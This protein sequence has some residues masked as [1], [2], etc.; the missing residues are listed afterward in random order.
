V[1]LVGLKK[2]GNDWQKQ[3]LRI[4]FITMPMMNNKVTNFLPHIFCIVVLGFAKNS[5]FDSCFLEKENSYLK[6]KIY[7][8]IESFYRVFYC[9]S[10]Q[11]LFLS[12]RS[13]WTRS[14]AS[15]SSTVYGSIPNTLLSKGK[16]L[17]STLKS[18]IFIFLKLDRV[19]SCV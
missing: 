18:L 14:E 1:L 15:I 4:Q 7:Y 5:S 17:K 16:N 3:N 8:E 10:Y 19:S 12:R 13:S 6:K 11:S 9:G 2:T